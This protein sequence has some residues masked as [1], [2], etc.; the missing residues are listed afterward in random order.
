MFRAGDYVDWLLAESGWILP[1]AS[2]H[3]LMTYTNC[4]IYSVVPTDDEQ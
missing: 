3:K 1:T 2:Q 4:Y